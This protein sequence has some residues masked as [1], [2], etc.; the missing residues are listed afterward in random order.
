MSSVYLDHAATTPVRD[1]VIAVME[2][3]LTARFGNPSSAHR[4][5]QEA[6]AALEHAR[7]RL[8]SAI[9]ARPSE[10]RFVRGGTE[11]DNLAIIGGVRA[12]AREGATPVLLAS[13]IEHSAVLEPARWLEGRGETELRLI[14]VSPDGNLGLDR[15]SDQLDARPSLASVMWANNETGLL[16]PMDEVV[17]WARTSCTVVHTDASQGVGK[18]PIDV[19]EVE[20]DLLT[21]TGHKLGG[22][23]GCGVLF[24]RDGIEIEPLIFGGGQERALRPGTE[25]VAGAVGLAEAIH[26]AVRDLEASGPRMAAL[27][28][29]LQGRLLDAIPGLRLNCGDAPRAPH[30]LSLGLPGIRNGADFLMALDLEGVAASGGSACHTGAAAASHVISALYGSDDPFATV[31][32]S[33][34]RASTEDEVDRGAAVVAEVWNRMKSP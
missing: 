6:S 19:G 1:D 28:D 9:G 29:R 17:S 15:V 26:L 31:R 10:I 32:L 20:V 22:P 3:Y 25:D 7:A 23:R 30:V 13:A 12:L 24:V 5:G 8:A 4:W 11:S 33:V 21:A 16:L 27:R 14:P 2:P 18:V 34:G